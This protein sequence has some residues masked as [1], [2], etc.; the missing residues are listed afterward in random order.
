MVRL[1][2]FNLLFF[3]IP[4]AVYALWLLA[5]RR[6]VGGTASWPSRVILWLTVAGAVLMV[7]VLV[8]FTS[9]TGAPLGATYVPAKIVEGV[10]VPGHFE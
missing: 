2:A 3:L 8:V 4:F 10:L 9:F 7:T 6:P 1:F 5:T